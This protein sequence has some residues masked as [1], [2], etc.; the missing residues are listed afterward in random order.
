[1]PAH[2]TSGGA[3][4]ASGGL[5]GQAS[6]QGTPTS[7]PMTADTPCPRFGEARATSGTRVMRPGHSHTHPSTGVPRLRRARPLIP[8]LA[9]MLVAALL[10]APGI[11]RAAPAASGTLTK[12]QKALSGGRASQAVSLLTKAIDA[13]SLSAKDTA[14]ALY[15]RGKAY[16]TLGKHAQA[17]ADLTAAL[18]LSGLDQGERANAFYNRALSY[19]ATGLRKR[20]VSDLK[21]ARRLAPQNGA[22]AEALASLRKGGARTA[23]PVARSESGSAPESTSS[24]SSG[25]PLAG[26]FG[27]LFSGSSGTSAGGPNG[28]PPPPAART[29][30]TRAPAPRKAQRTASLRPAGAHRPAGAPSAWPT[31]VVP[32]TALSS[33]PPPA[34]RPSAS[35]GG[36]MGGISAFFGN[37]FSSA[38]PSPQTEPAAAPSTGAPAARPVTSHAGRTAT[39]SWSARKQA[40]RVRE[41]QAAPRRTARAAPPP[42]AAIPVLSGKA[43]T[44]GL[45]RYLLQVA[46]VRDENEARAIAARIGARHA[47]T[48]GGIVPIIDS[49]PLG[50]MGT[51]YRVQLGPFA[52]KGKTLK[53]CNKLRREGVDCFLVT[54]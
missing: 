40:A 7:T 50:N 36:V 41:P 37:L 27:G 33:A 25:N 13:K 4:R 39:S 52:D 9:A 32:G 1:M 2:R 31:E 49:A 3:H 43:A 46:A 18:W 10:L 26:L 20:A 42:A 45:G 34:A 47:K 53:L 44:G 38:A 29:A 11:A 5:V 12:A 35:S 6:L 23:S 24:S 48:L 54:R 22:I 51:F 21:N 8:A 30:A 28:S 19:R 15:L 16:R 17:I 14:K